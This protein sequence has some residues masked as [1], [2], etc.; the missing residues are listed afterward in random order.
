M[1]RWAA[2]C[3]ALAC[4][5]CGGHST[6]PTASVGTK[7]RAG[8][9]RNGVVSTHAAAAAVITSFVAEP[10]SVT[11]GSSSTLRWTTQNATGV[12]LTLPTG[13]TLSQ[14]ANGALALTFERRGT[15][16]YTLTA[17]GGGA[18]TTA[19]ASV[20]VGDG[21]PN[22][23]P[24]L[25]LRTTP[26]ASGGEP[27]VISG[28]VPL[29]VSFSLCQSSDP[30][31]NPGAPESGDTLNWQFHFGDDGTQPFAP[32]GR[33]NPNAERFCRAE[34]TYTSPGRYTA[35]LVV[36]DKNLSD[37]ADGVHA[38]ARQVQEVTII[39]GGDTP[40]RT[41][42]TDFDAYAPLTPGTALGIPGVSFG[43][44]EVDTACCFN[45]LTGNALF[46]VAGTFDIT[47]DE[48]LNFY[49][50]RF[51]YNFFPITLQGLRD[52]NVV[53]TTSLTAA[54]DPVSG[55]EEG[56]TGGSGPSFDTLRFS[57]FVMAIDNFRAGCE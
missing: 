4:L 3:L 11:P 36:A 30:D 42:A 51:A 45:T 35:T 41:V 53:F 2:C 28:A 48:P 52:G 38:H 9:V 17:T 21:G 1:R 6:E 33:F 57:G 49:S 16:T 20:S 27:P 14:P 31:E 29:T 34:H 39:A 24:Q 12:T 18:T 19:T 40:C 5:S 46:D 23:P 37:E 47:F 50:F 25:V 43:D 26:P 15:F 8:W 7:T 56:A 44:S 10:R 54:V 55:I 13:V 22:R 32:D